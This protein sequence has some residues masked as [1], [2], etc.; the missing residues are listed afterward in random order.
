MGGGVWVCVCVC[1]FH[2]PEI[3][4]PGCSLSVFMGGCGGDAEGDGEG[5]GGCDT[6]CSGVS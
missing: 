1:W 4:A 2:V 5:G 3:I 6:R